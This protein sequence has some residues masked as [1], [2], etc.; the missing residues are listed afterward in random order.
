MTLE[1]AKQAA[2]AVEPNLAGAPFVVAHRF[3]RNGRVL[4]LALTE[5]LKHSCERARVW[6]GRSFLQ[7][8]KN[9]AHGFDPVQSRRRGGKDGV[10]LLDRDFVPPNAM[11][12]KIFASYLDRE[13]SGADAVARRLGVTRA[14]LLG[15]RL[16][17]H[18]GRL[19]GVLSVQP[20]ADWLVLVDWDDSE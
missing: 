10:Y 17:A 4:H 16:V 8:F 18:H 6:K 19:L 5:R 2:E 1:E 20:D 11:M 15:A 14:S 7:A 12:R 13:D 9:A 3:E